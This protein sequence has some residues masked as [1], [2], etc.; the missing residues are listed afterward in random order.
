MID[1]N[2]V[3][4]SW[5]ELP[6]GSYTNH[7]Q[8]S[9][10]CQ[11]EVDVS[12]DQII[13]HPT[14]GQMAAIAP[15]RILSFDIE[16]TGLN[17]K[18]SKTIQI[19]N[20]VTVHGEAEP[21]TKVIFTLGGCS[22]IE[23][24]IVR[25]FKDERSL[26]MAWR[27]FVVE[28]DPD[29]FTGYNINGFDFPFLVERA[30]LLGLGGF[31][32]FGRDDETRCRVRNKETTTKAYGTRETKVVDIPGRTL[33]DMCEIIRRDHKLPSYKLNTSANTS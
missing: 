4:M 6:A 25:S 33:L 20:V 17:S 27:D 9:S 2:I 13:S 22:D 14:E 21:R 24:A 32:Y 19:A 1:T 29:V 7:S 3:G 26:L 15:L 8:G 11:Y 23:G 30:E 10:H 28:A 18:T 31:P 5:I 16:S 12:Y